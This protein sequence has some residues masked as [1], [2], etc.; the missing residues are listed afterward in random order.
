MLKN[1]VKLFKG[2]VFAKYDV[3]LVLLEF[4]LVTYNFAVSGV[5]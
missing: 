5:G 4:A 3:K 1:K 2:Y